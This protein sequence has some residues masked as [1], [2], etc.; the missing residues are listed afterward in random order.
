[1]EYICRYCGRICK[2]DNSLRNHERLCKE[3]PDR[4]IL[5]SNFIKWN[6]YRA[7][8]HLQKASN[9]YKNVHKMICWSCI[10][11]R[12][13]NKLKSTTQNVSIVAERE[14]ESKGKRYI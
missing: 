7:G 9:Q 8:K 12:G 10:F 1:M 3:N 11:H 5:V 4:Q 13:K 2:N 14:E 6:E